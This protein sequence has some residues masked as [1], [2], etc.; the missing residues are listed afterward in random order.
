MGLVLFSFPLCHIF[1]F[2]KL[3]C[4]TNAL[5]TKRKYYEYQT[6]LQSNEW[7]NAK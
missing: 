4:Q 2:D 5:T 1:Y 3:M 6:L 7:Y